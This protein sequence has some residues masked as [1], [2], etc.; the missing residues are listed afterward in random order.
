M[1]K[2]DMDARQLT[3]KMLTELRKRGVSRVQN[4]QSP[5]LVA[6]ALALT[7]KP[8]MDGWHVIAVVDGPHWML[9]KEE[10]ESLT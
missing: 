9:E 4:G 3:H 8:C 1:K 7:G 2:K 10:A 5:E 6:K